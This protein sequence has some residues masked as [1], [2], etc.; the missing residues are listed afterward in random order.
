MRAAERTADPFEAVDRRL[1]VLE[2]RFD[3]LEGR[4]AVLEAERRRDRDLLAAIVQHMPNVVFGASELLAHGRVHEAL[5]AALTA[6]GIQNP[7][8]LGKR[9]RAILARPVAGFRVEQVGR[10]RAGWLWSVEVEP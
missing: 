2:S 6:A 7:R 10:D 8:T 5:G 4:T 9:L 3:R 1:A